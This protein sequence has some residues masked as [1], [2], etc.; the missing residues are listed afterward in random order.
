[1]LKATATATIMQRS[2]ENCI[3]F[4]RPLL[5]EGVGESMVRLEHFG[6]VCSVLFVQCCLFSAV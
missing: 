5:V 6:A 2:L 4:G 1:V 3:Q